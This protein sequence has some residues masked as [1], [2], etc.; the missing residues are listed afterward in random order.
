MTALNKN[1]PTPRR[2]PGQH[3]DPVAGS[4]QIFSGALVV[5]N[6]THFAAP[7]TAATGLRT[8]GVAVDASDNR[9]GSN[10]DGF[11]TTQTG[12]H[13]FINA[14]DITREHIGTSA[15]IVDDQTV[16]AVSTD[17][18]VVGRIDDVEPDGVWVVI[19]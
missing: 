7:A 10:G 18:S 5:L 1:R 12:P 15:Y 4:V 2:L 19:E 3:V 17:S 14:G 13:R 9:T 16:T 6:A 8:R 11:I